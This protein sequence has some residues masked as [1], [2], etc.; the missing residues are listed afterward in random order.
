[1]SGVDSRG[2]RSSNLGGRSSNMGGRSSNLGD[3]QN[4]PSLVIKK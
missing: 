4:E 1:M 3:P 2:G